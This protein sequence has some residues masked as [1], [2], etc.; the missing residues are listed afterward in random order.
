MNLATICLT[1]PL[2]AGA[3]IAHAQTNTN[4]VALPDINITARRSEAPPLRLPYLVHDI[5]AELTP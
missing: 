2:L 3:T 5:T 4:L 1:L